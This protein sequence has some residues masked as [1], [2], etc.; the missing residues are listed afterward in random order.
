MKCVS[1]DKT[2][3]EDSIF[4]EFCGTK[5]EEPNKKAAKKTTKEPENI[6]MIKNHLEF[7]GYEVG[8]NYG[9]DGKFNYFAKHANKSN[10]FINY[11]PDFGFLFTSN[12][13]FEK[14]KIAKNR[15]KFLE[16]VN[17]MNRTAFLGAYCLTESEDTLNCAAFYPYEY[18]KK[19]FSKFIE[20]FESEIRKKLQ[21]KG[22]DDFT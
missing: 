20:F 2:I 3:S 11:I 22:T 12:W 18:S 14:E 19:T 7:L 10:L 6:V 9:E 8:E 15:G 21:T 1:C 16:I 13:G 4:C 5:I 17:E